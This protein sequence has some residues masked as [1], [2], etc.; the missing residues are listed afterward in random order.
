MVHTCQE[1]GYARSVLRLA[2]SRKWNS[3]E[4]AKVASTPWDLHQP[5]DPEVVFRERL[6]I[7]AEMVWTRLLLPDKSTSKLLIWMNLD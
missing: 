3:D 7:S 2:E 6:M 4:L 5:K 1:I